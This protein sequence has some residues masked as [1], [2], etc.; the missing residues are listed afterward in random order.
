[1]TLLLAIG[2]HDVL[3]DGHVPALIVVLHDLLEVAALEPI[4]REQR[5][6]D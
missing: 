6:V 5:A 1:M 2:G 3:L 4:A